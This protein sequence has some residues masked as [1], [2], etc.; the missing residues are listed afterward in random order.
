MTRILAL[1]GQAIGRP[2]GLLKSMFGGF[3]SELTRDTIRPYRPEQ[4]YMRGPG[5]AWHRKHGK[6]HG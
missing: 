5:P 4:Y 3:W 2:F 6:R 1:S